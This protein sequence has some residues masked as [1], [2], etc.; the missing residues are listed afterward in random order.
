MSAILNLKTVADLSGVN[1]LKGGVDGVKSSSDKLN[2]T[3]DA[4]VDKLDQMTGGAI[5]LGK[6]LLASTGMGAKGFKIL[7]T[8]I[9]STGIGALVVAVG[10]LVAYFTNTQRGADKV[11]QV[12]K[13][14]GAT[15]DVL[16]DRLSSFGEGLF[17]ILSGDF[18][19]GL[20]TLTNSFKG[21]GEEIM[22]E[23]KAALQLEKD[24]Q[25]LQDREV[26]FIKV[27]ASK[28]A[29][30]E[31]ARLDA[32]DESKSNEERAAA[33]QEA[34]KI[35]NELTDEQIEIEKE[36]AR[37]I[38][39]RVDLG[40]SSRD[41]LREQAE[42][43]ARV[44][45]LESERARRLRSVQTRLNAFVNVQKEDNEVTRERIMLDEMERNLTIAYDPE[46]DPEI[47]KV[48][49]REEAKRTEAQKTQDFLMSIGKQK[50]SYD[51]LLA[52]FDDKIAEQKIKNQYSILAAT[53]SVLT[54]GM[55][56]A[57]EGSAA[58][59]GFASA[60]ALFSAFLAINKTLADPK[61][62]FPANAIIATS[63]GAQAL[64][65]VAKI[66]SIDPKGGNSS[67]ASTSL[68]IPRANES[69]GDNFQTP[70]FG[71]LNAGVGGT[72]GAD[73][74]ASRS[75]VVLQDIRDKESLDER[76]RDS[77]RLG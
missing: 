18:E 31:Q 2:K 59:K 37:I 8:A 22:N 66:N 52:S 63:I 58:A 15:V 61:L 3:F 62:L 12:F 24:M 23:S 49:K 45:E 33:L 4:G 64:F 50:M 47:R 69:G 13:A 25:K 71:F 76:I 46:N 39:E 57:E 75:Y 60:Q 26:E 5:T 43:E 65:N 17:Q 40:E 29:A 48:R 53:Q 19:M 44:I 70:E 14:I 41:D 68:N 21:V 72:Q 34:I 10:T 16:I 7:R 35:Q 11:N 36:R 1:K 30:I 42:A 28:R 56:I 38:R 54:A 32:E 6:Q 27:Q 73:F 20:E 51:D 74:G 77:S 9:I 55:A 67:S